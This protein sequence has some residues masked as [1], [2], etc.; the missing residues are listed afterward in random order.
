MLLLA[1]LGCSAHSTENSACFGG[2][3]I[4]NVISPDID[5]QEEMEYIDQ[6][7]NEMMEIAERRDV[8]KSQRHISGREDSPDPINSKNGGKLQSKKGKEKTQS[9]GRMVQKGNSK[10]LTTKSKPKTK[11]KTKTVA[12]STINSGSICADRKAQLNF[13]RI[14]PINK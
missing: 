12:S 9:S 4:E 1:G 14:P 2:G 10:P 6:D 7:Y 11:T 5:I 13:L 3:D 8:S